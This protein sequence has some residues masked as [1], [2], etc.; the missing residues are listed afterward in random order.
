MKS[1]EGSAG[2][3]GVKK[4][5]TVLVSDKPRNFTFTGGAMAEANEGQVFSYPFTVVNE[6]FPYGPFDVRVSGAEEVEVI[7]SQFLCRQCKRWNSFL[8]SA[9]CM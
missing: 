8:R 5:I 4:E 3:A 2:N 7:R 1:S 6:D 9:V